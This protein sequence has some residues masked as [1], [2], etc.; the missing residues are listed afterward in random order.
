[1]TNMLNR[2]NLGGIEYDVEE[3]D[4]ESGYEVI[5]NDEPLLPLVPSIGLRWQF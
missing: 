4:D 2:R 5:A 1:M 3:L